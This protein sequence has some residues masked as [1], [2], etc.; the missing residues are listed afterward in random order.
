[1]QAYDAARDDLASALLK[2][3][4]ELAAAPN[5]APAEPVSR[6]KP[7]Y[8]KWWFYAGLV[9]AVIVVGAATS[10]SDEEQPPADSPRGTV[11]VGVTV[12]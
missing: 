6:S 3:A 1:M 2:R 8:K 5:G 4:P 9:A 11:S 12:Q 7:I 10:K